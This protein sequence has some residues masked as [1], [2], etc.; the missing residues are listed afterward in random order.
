MIKVIV[1]QIENIIWKINSNDD[2]NNENGDVKEKRK[3]KAIQVD[4]LI[5]ANFLQFLFSLSFLY[6]FTHLHTHFI[7][8][9]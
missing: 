4:L 8:S 3:N 5:I 7:G 1:I 9:I 2:D 6:C